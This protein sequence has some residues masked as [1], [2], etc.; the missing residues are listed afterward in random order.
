MATSSYT[1]NFGLS[2]W[3][4]TDRPKREDFVSDNN[5]IDNVLG[6]HIGNIDMH[7]TNSEK[8]KALQPYT[9]MIYSGNGSDNRALTT[10]FAPKLVM[11]FKKD[12]APVEYANS[13]AVINFGTA[14]YGHGGSAG[15]GVTS[16]GFSVR[17]QSTASDGKRFSLNED[18]YQYFAVIFR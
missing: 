14:V 6:S 18:G 13:A 2:N 4:P 5:I 12:A 1:S 17:Q 9:T 7:L 3:A 16:T 15:V 10:E 11:V 8:E